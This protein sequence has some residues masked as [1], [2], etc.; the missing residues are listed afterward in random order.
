MPNRHRPH[1]GITDKSSS[2]LSEQMRGAKYLLWICPCWNKPLPVIENATQEQIKLNITEPKPARTIVPV[3]VTESALDENINVCTSPLLPTVLA[4]KGAI[5]TEG[6][7]CDTLLVKTEHEDD[8]P[9]DE[10][11]VTFHLSSIHAEPTSMSSSI[12]TSDVFLPHHIRRPRSNSD[13]YRYKCPKGLD[14]ISDTK[15][16]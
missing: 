14:S 5:D 8:L 6:I 12:Q 1:V 2:R 3:I 13:G 11:D 9:S 7:T 16:L 4:N 10:N 15:S